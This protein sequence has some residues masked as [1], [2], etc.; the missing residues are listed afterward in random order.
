ML[1]LVRKKTM[2]S[3]FSILSETLERSFQ[4]N[5]Y[6]IFYSAPGRKISTPNRNL[7]PQPIAIHLWRAPTLL[8]EFFVLASNLLS[9]N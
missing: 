9:A 8:S 1:V 4:F 5:K 7:A 3:L 2:E 6:F